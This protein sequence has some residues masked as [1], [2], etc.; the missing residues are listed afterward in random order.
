MLNHDNSRMMVFHSMVIREK[1]PSKRCHI[2]SNGHF[3]N[4]LKLYCILEVQFY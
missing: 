2:R 3:K 4:T 1:P